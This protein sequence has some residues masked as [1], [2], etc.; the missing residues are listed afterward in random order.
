MTV[1]EIWFAED[2]LKGKMGGLITYEGGSKKS[3]SLIK[4][5]TVGQEIMEVGSG[6]TH[7]LLSDCEK[8][9]LRKFAKAPVYPSPGRFNAMIVGEAPGR[10]EDR[11]GIGFIGAS[12]SILWNGDTAR[13]C[14]GLAQYGIT[15]EDFWV[16][17]FGKCYPGEIKTPRKKHL[18]ACQVWWKR[19][20][21][22]VKPFVLLSF[23]NTG[24]NAITGE[25]KG[26]M[27]KSGEVEWNDELGCFVVYCLHPAATLYHSDNAEIYNRGILSFLDIYLN[28]G[29]GSL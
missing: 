2:L 7:T 15:R 20:V 13:G 23:G 1:S 4:E 9:E 29:Y 28:L 27:D 25:G 16:S 6:V 14:V 19:E 8:C 10:D 17:N 26:I 3:I 21:E 22:M 18:T 11:E 12:G 24:L 5:N